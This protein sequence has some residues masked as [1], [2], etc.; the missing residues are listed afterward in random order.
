MRGEE[1]RRGKE[2]GDERIRIER[3]L[4]EKKRAESVH[5]LRMPTVIRLKNGTLLLAL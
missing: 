2:R 4:K 3:E 1:R 5:V